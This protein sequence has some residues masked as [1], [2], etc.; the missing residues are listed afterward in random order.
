M[1]TDGYRVFF[2]L[3]YME[4][5]PKNDHLFIDDLVGGLEHE[6]YFS[7]SWECHDPFVN[8]QPVIYEDLHWKW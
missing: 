1:G 7:I 6:L 4:N 2:Y 5:G 8:H 3:T